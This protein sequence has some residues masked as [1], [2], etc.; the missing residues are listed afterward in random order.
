MR[1]KELN[2]L[3]LSQ[4]FDF[5]RITRI[6]SGLWRLDYE[7]PVKW[8]PS[9]YASKS[10]A[11]YAALIGVEDFEIAGYTTQFIFWNW[12]KLPVYARKSK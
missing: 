4:D 1:L 11:L 9:Y 2:R 6:H 3:A 12:K 10:D 5:N 7:V 8:T